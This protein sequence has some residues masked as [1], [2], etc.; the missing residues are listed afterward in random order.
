MPGSVPTAATENLN[1]S[2]DSRA[3][4]ASVIGACRSTA[5][6]LLDADAGQRRPLN[7]LQ[8]KEYSN[9]QLLLTLAVRKPPDLSTN[10]A[11]Q[12][13]ERHCAG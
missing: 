11:K 4:V 9:A 13:Y 5:I 7:C 10:R 6:R 8:C 12:G 2:G 1:A 3:G